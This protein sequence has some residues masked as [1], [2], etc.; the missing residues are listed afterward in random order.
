MSDAAFD[1]KHCISSE[2]C[3]SCVTRSLM[4]APLRIGGQYVRMQERGRRLGGTML[5]YDLGCDRAQLAMEACFTLRRPPQIRASFRHCASSTTS[6]LLGV[7]PGRPEVRSKG[8]SEDPLGRGRS[9][10]GVPLLL[11]LAAA[12]ESGG[13]AGARLG[14]TGRRGRRAHGRCR[15]AGG[16]ARGVCHECSSVLVMP[17][18]PEGLVT[19]ERRTLP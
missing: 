5:G 17:A 16:R 9:G 6:Q 8:R 19:A 1:G 18:A 12:S 10:L 4:H 13:G 14:R 15:R 3:S 7:P 2:R 11:P